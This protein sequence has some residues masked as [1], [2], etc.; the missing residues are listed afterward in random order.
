MLLEDP[1]ALPLEEQEIGT[2]RCPGRKLTDGRVGQG[3][4]DTQDVP[5]L[6]DAEVKALEA[7]IEERSCKKK[8]HG[9]CFPALLEEDGLDGAPIE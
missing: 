9:V 4:R 2:A 3:E 5:S 8:S 1:L 6:S 7:E